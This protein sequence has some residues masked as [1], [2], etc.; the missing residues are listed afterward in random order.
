MSIITST[1]LSSGSVD[2]TGVFDQLMRGVKAQLT[3][4]FEASRIIGAEYSKVYL[5]A[6]SQ[7]LQTATQFIL[8][9]Q[10]SDKKADLLT[11]QITN[12]VSQNTLIQSQIAKTDSEKALV[13]QR[14]ATERAETEDLTVGATPVEGLVKAKKDL[15]VAQKNGFARDAEQKLLKQMLDTVSVRLS[16]DTGTTVSANGLSDTNIKAVVDVARSGVGLAA[17]T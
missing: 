16:T 2:G 15:Y 6:M 13:D 14:K 1:Q 7:A 17:S 4:E 8:N 12:A 11:Q 9:Q 10:E 5:G 3:E